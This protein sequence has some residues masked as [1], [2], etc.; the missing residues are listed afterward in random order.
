MQYYSKILGLNSEADHVSREPTAT[1]RIRDACAIYG[2]SG[3]Y[4]MTKNLRFNAGIDNWFDKDPTPTKPSGSK[5]SG[6]NY[7]VPDQTFYASITASF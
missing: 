5:T 1:A 3:Q 7:Y 2:L 6:N 4:M